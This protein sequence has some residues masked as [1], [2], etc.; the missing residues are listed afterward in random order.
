MKAK[1]TQENLNQTMFNWITPKADHSRRS[2]IYVYVY[3]SVSLFSYQG[4]YMIDQ[5]FL[6]KSIFLESEFPGALNYPCFISQF[7]F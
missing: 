1:S 2:L 4:A 3:L 5:I 7:H 6:G